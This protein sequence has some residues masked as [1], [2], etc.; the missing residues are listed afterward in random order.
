VT[1]VQTPTEL[2]ISIHDEGPGIPE[3]DLENVFNR[4]FRGKVGE[5][6]GSSGTGLGLSIAKGIVEAHNGRVWAENRPTGGTTFSIA[7][8]LSANQPTT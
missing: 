3:P 2:I 7:L 5:T 4:F 8:P 6:A 1:A